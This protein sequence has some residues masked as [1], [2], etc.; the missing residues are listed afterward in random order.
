MRLFELGNVVLQAGLTLRMQLAQ[1]LRHP[2]Q[3]QR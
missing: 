1:N 3:P 2:E